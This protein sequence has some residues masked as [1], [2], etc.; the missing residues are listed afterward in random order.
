MKLKELTQKSLICVL[1]LI[2]YAYI[3][4]LMG[5][6]VYFNWQYA[7]DNGF[8]KWFLLGE[9]I[10][11]AKAVVWPYYLLSEY[12][13]NNKSL[14][15]ASLEYHAKAN[16]LLNDGE[17]FSTIPPQIATE[18]FNLRKK[19]LSKAESVDIEK[20]RKIQNGF[21]AHYQDEFIAGLKLLIEG[22]ETSDSQKSVEGQYLLLAF[23]SWYLSERARYYPEDEQKQ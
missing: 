11:T 22:H 18:M 2:S 14:V 3:M 7:Q 13:D 20:L 17:A 15:I 23:D 4:G 10:P 6:A 19:S 21:A 8:V 1:Y 12:T 5:S 9:I 16:K